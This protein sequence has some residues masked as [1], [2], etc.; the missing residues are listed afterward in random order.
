M[1]AVTTTSSNNRSLGFVTESA[2]LTDWGKA[3]LQVNESVSYSLFFAAKVL[4]D[5]LCSKDLSF[6]ICFKAG[7]D[8][9]NSFQNKHKEVIFNQI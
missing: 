5:S 1:F 4:A 7:G 3:R 6:H 8:V 9:S 2:L